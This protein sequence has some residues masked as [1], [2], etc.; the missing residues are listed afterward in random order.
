MYGKDGNTIPQTLL[1]LLDDRPLLCPFSQEEGYTYT[2]NIYFYDRNPASKEL[3]FDTNLEQKEPFMR[4]AVS[5]HLQ[6]K[7]ED[8]SRLFVPTPSDI[9]HGIVMEMN[10]LHR[11][12]TPTRK[13]LDKLLHSTDSYRD[14]IPEQ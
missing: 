8:L 10:Q 12:H 6:N 2:S 5:F 7:T 9:S 1:T 14:W 3:Y 13:V 11:Y 4:Y